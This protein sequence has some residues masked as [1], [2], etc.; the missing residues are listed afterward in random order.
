MIF[1]VFPLTYLCIIFVI[2]CKRNTYTTRNFSKNGNN[3]VSK[4]RYIVIDQI[5]KIKFQTLN[6]SKNISTLII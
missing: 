2:F 1:K 4:F 5:N 6:I 3:L